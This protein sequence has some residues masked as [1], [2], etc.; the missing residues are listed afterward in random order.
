MKNNDLLK[1]NL[2][3]FAD[4]PDAAAL[5][6]L[7][8]ELTGGGDPAPAPASDPTPGNDPT[9]GDDPKK[10]DT[11]KG[12]DPTPGDDPKPAD[13]P[14]PNDDPKPADDPKGEEKKTNPIAQMRETV[15]E[16]DARIKELEDAQ[17][18]QEELQEKLFRAARLG[19]KGETLEEVLEN[20]EAH[21]VKTEAEKSGLTEEQIRKE[22]ELET[23]L[24]ELN[25]AQTEVIFNQRAY[26]LQVSKGLSSEQLNKF[27]GDAASIGINLLAT[28]IDFKKIYERLYPEDQSTGV[29][30]EK[31][32]TIAE[33]EAQIAQLKGQTVPGSGVPGQE[34]KGSPTGDPEMD[35]L[36]GDLT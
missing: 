8:K 9:P 27:I 11:T 6:Q 19:I 14:K 32:K 30:A 21:D 7:G 28:G 15:K 12:G 10:T 20:L 1:L 17:K 16:R 33:L 35:K 2:Q 24:K 3:M 4:D 36:L 26:N 18:S 22:K 25:S 5:E 34:G 31:D 23:K 13:D 29:I